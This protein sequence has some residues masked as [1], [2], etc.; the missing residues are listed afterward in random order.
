LFWEAPVNNRGARAL[1]L[2]RGDTVVAVLDAGYITLGNKKFQVTDTF[3]KGRVTVGYNEDF[4]SVQLVQRRDGSGVI[5]LAQLGQANRFRNLTRKGQVSSSAIANPEPSA[6][7]VFAVGLAVVAA[8][9][10][11][12]QVPHGR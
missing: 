10:R 5:K 9:Q 4:G 7:L 3:R 1:G 6:A 11:S 12:R 2:D 8:T